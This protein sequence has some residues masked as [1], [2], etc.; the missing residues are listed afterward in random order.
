MNA[1]LWKQVMKYEGEPVLTIS[2]RRPDPS[3]GDRTQAR[4]G[5][6]YKRLCEAWQTRWNTV[7]YPAAC[8]ALAAARAESRPFQP[9]SAALDFTVPLE[10]ETRWSVVLD[11][12]ERGGEARAFTVR[13]ADVWDAK[14]GTPLSLGDCLPPKVR[15]RALTQ[16]L[17]RQTGARIAGGESLFY[18]D[19][20][21]RAK[22]AFS[23]W[24]FFLDP[25]G[26]KIFYPMLA[27]G[28]AAEGIPVFSLDVETLAPKEKTKKTH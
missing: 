23:P 25:D 1:W 4:I 21:L 22:T 9:W 26:P 12:V 13:S 18:A 5:Q 16:A 6:Y 27:L 20:V 11:A 8:A 15:R 24:R 14:T 2:L 17:Q 7:L 10:T 3:S 19:A 28:P